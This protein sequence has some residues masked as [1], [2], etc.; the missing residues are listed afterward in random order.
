MSARRSRRSVAGAIALLGVAALTLPAMAALNPLPLPM[1]QLETDEPTRAERRGP[2][3]EDTRRAAGPTALTAEVRGALVAANGGRVP[4]FVYLDPV[5]APANPPSIAFARTLEGRASLVAGLQSAHAAARTGIDTTLAALQAAG[6]AGP[7]TSYWIVNAVALEADASALSTLALVPGVTRITLNETFPLE[8]RAPDGPPAFASAPDQTGIESDAAWNLKSVH[9]DEVWDLLGV[10]GSGVTVAIID[11][12]VHF[13]HQDLKERYRGYYGP[14]LEPRNVGNWWCP[15]QMCGTGGQHPWDAGGHGTHVLGSILGDKTGVAPGAEWIAAMACDMNE[16]SDAFILAAMQWVLAGEGDRTQPASVLNLSLEKSGPLDYDMKSGIDAL[17]RAGVVTVVAAGNRGQVRSPG[18]F[19]ST[20]TVGALDETGHVPAWSGRG[21]TPW[22]EPKPEVV[23]PGV[24]VVSTI[25]GGGY[26]AETGTSMATPHVAGVAA[27]MLQVRPDLSPADVKTVLKNSATPLGST[28]PGGASGW[29]LVNAFAAVASLD[30]IGTIGGRVSSSTG[31]P[32]RWGSR[33]RIARPD[34]VAMASTVPSVSG[35]YTVAIRP[36]DYMV[37][38]EAFGYISSTLST[39]VEAAGAS[40][41]NFALTP[42]TADAG[43]FVGQVTDKKGE[44]LDG[45]IVLVDTPVSKPFEAGNF[46]VEGLPPGT[47]SVRVESPGH[48]VATD[49]ITIEALEVVSATYALDGA[50]TVL[51]LDGDAWHFSGAL[52]FYTDSLD[53]LG[54]LYSTWRVLDRE[55]PQLPDAATMAQYD[56]VIWTQDFSSPGYMRAGSLLTGYLDQGGHLLLAGQD[57]V[58]TDSG[59]TACGEG[60]MRQ[61]YVDDRLFLKFVTDIAPSRSVQGAIGGPLEGI[62][63]TLNGFDSLNNQLAPDVID[64]ANPLHGIVAAEYESGGGAAAYVAS[65]VGYRAFVLGF[66]LEGVN[67]D[68]SRDALLGA[69]MAGFEADLPPTILAVTDEP[70]K[71]VAAGSQALYTVTLHSTAPEPREA[72]VGVSGNTWPTELLTAAFV[73]PLGPVMNLGSCRAMQF[74]VRVTVPENARRATSDSAELSLALAGGPTVGMQIETR[75]P[76]PLLLVDGDM[77]IGSEARYE[78]ALDAAGIP[79]DRHVVTPDPRQITA[80]GPPT[81][82]RLVLYPIVVWFTGFHPHKDSHLDVETMQKLADYLQTGGRLFFSSEDHLN[83]RGATPYRTDR[84]FHREFFGVRAYQQD[85]GAASI[86]GAVGTPYENIGPCRLRPS[87]ES[88]N[89]FFADRLLLGTRSEG[90]LQSAPDLMVATR[91]FS[92]TIKTAFLAFDAGN[93]DAVCLD[94]ILA[95]TM[96]WFSPLTESV[97]SADRLAY[98]SGD[99]VRL[100]VRLRNNGPRDLS[101][102]VARWTL[103][104]GGAPANLPGGGWRWDAASRTLTWSNALRTASPL[105][106]EI[107]FILDADLPNGT[108]LAST[109]QIEDGQGLVIEREAPFRV[110]VADLSASD[111]TASTPG[112]VERGDIVRFTVTVRNR[113]TLGVSDFIVTDTLPIGLVLLER[114]VTGP[115]G[116]L[117][118]I[119][120]RRIVWRSSVGAGGQSSLSYDARVTAVIGGYLTNVAVVDGGTERTTIS[121]R[122]LVAPNLLLPWVSKRAILPRH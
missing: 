83:F 94:P 25:P 12:G 24:G 84:L 72:T 101:A 81:A 99:T 71:I 56:I 105:T 6:Q 59:S 117:L 20:I 73:A 51:V 31:A 120:P 110:N 67:G 65:C 35:Q 95:R 61:R 97:V 112:P 115:D 15:P 85:I 90:I 47:Y 100:T 17:V 50:P 98:A 76:A 89:D 30:S 114:T 26:R 16:C 46:A 86:R 14:N 70:S 1:A 49:E 34:G 23:A 63:V 111:K 91:Y 48:R 4:V 77:W 62:S 7:D 80:D 79:F 33:V 32:P 52:S 96:D 41:V 10:D 92:D 39:T 60:W 40:V 37:T 82:D 57:V 55:N 106:T 87:G 121:A 113:G 108:A 3:V 45:R 68:S 74:G 75:T 2:P 21:V 53:R 104:A 69:I 38:A 116:E 8:P 29:G 118:E 78:G 28:A 107:D 102:V 18:S 88:L 9:A 42:R 54:Y 11:T 109:L 119:S 122:V 13:P 36:G 19:T 44:P 58:C 27:L 22:F 103:P 5:V 93:L 66:G 43:F 64:V